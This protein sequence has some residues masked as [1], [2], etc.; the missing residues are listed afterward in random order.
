MPSRQRVVLTI[1][2]PPDIAAECRDLAKA[3]G[4]SLSLFFREMLAFYRK[5]KFKD[6]FYCLQKYGDEKNKGL[7]Y[8]REKH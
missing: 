2:V 8:L 1:S 3:R 5:E 6:E 7:E 4:E